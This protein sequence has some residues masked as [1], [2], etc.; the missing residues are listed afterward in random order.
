MAAPYTSNRRS[1]LPA[2]P[3][4]EHEAQPRTPGPFIT[5]A[6]SKPKT[7]TRRK[8][9][10]AKQSDAA[11]NAVPATDDEA[12]Y[13]GLTARD[14]TNAPES[15]YMNSAQLAYFQAL[16]MEMRQEVLERESGIRERLQDTQEVMKPGP[17]SPRQEPIGNLQEVP[18]ATLRKRA[19]AKNLPGSWTRSGLERELT[20]ASFQPGQGGWHRGLDSDDES[21]ANI[22]GEELG[23]GGAFDDFD[24][25][26]GD[27]ELDQV[28]KV[29]PKSRKPRKRG[30]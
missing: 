14:L 18:T 22:A 16:L 6:T 8:T 20:L 11:E 25:V 3:A 10:T 4:G 1:G 19:R 5:V 23:F 26:G 27:Q 13:A 12:V 9:S 2:L 28:G 30:T 24:G 17:C 15:D 7:G 29:R 21:L